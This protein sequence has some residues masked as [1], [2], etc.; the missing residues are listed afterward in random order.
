MPFGLSAM[1]VAAHGIPELRVAGAVLVC[2][3]GARTAA[4]SFNRLADWEIDRRNP[5]TATR[6]ELVSKAVGWVTMVGGV[7]LLVGGA[8]C[9][10]PLCL[11]LSPVAVGIVCFYSLTKRFTWASHGFL[12]L[13]LGTAPVGGW[14]AVRGR[15]DS[16]TPIILGLAVGL[17]VAG[18]DLVYSLQDRKFDEGEGLKSF[19]AKFGEEV[20]LR[21]ARGLHIMAAGLLG[22]FGWVAGFGWRY[23]MIW[24]AVVGV[25]GVETVWTKSQRQKA[26]FQAN[27]MVSLLVFMGVVW[28]IFGR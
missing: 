7:V 14:L 15:F 11:V 8:Y 4:M 22:M 2:L 3:V 23:G 25:L 18:F 28:E 9:L 12:G 26:F 21:M 27:A 6:S 5:R 13:A 19:P 20:S 24:L 17:W 1:L 16:W 10:N